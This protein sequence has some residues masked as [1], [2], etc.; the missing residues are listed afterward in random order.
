MKLRNTIAI[1]GLVAL[2]LN[3][4]DPV[5]CLSALA[6]IESG[7][8]D[9]KIGRAGERSKYQIKKCVWTDWQKADEH[10]PFTRCKGKLATRCAR[11]HSAWLSHQ[12]FTKHN[13]FPSAAQFYC[14]WNMGFDGFAK[15]EFLVSSCPRRV[16]ERAERFANLVAA[17]KEEGK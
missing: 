5:V 1:L 17:L 14:M 4:D 15:R 6:Q 2:H 16:Q 9:H 12:F 10:L 11:D 13:K 7:G 8:K 3:A